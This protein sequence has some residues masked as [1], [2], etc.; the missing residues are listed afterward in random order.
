MSR[1]RRKTHTRPL[2]KY[3]GKEKRMTLLM[4]LIGK[5][6]TK[7][8][9]L[10]LRVIGENTTMLAPRITGNKNATQMRMCVIA[11]EPLGIL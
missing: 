3:T 9:I 6:E 11:A 4:T 1:T 8:T 7:E 10:T 5:E 2:V